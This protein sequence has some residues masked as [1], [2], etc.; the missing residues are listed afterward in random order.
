MTP[1]LKLG[2]YTHRKFSFRLTFFS[3]QKH[4]PELVTKNCRSFTLRQQKFCAAYTQFIVLK[5]TV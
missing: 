2:T 5:G 3:V 4:N 1:D